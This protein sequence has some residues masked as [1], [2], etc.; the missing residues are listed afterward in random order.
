MARTI[1]ADAGLRRN[2]GPPVWRRDNPFFWKTLRAESRRSFLFV[3]MALTIATLAA[4]LLGGMA[5]ERR[6]DFGT[7]GLI[8]FLGISTLGLTFLAVSL[9]HT[10][11][12]LGARGALATSLQ[13]ETRRQTLEGLLLTPMPRAAMLLAMAVA[14][15]L[16]ASL[17]ALA[18]LPLYV[19]LN[20]LGG[21]EWR[22][23]GLLY[24]LFGLAAFAPPS[25][26]V[27]ALSGAAA[28]P[29]APQLMAVGRAQEQRRAEGAAGWSWFSLIWM[30]VALRPLLGVLGGSWLSH[31][32]SVLPPSVTRLGPLVVFAWPYSLTQTLGS[33][34]P[35]YNVHVVPFVYALPLIFG[36]WISS[37]L[38]SAAALTA[39]SPQEMIRTGLFRRHAALARL[40]NRTALLC[41]LGVMWRVWVLGGDTAA[42]TGHASLDPA[43]DAAGLLL[44]TGSVAQIQAAWRALGVAPRGKGSGRGRPPLRLVRRALRVAWRPL[45]LLVWMFALTCAFGGLSPFVGPVLGMAGRLGLVALACVVFAVGFHVWAASFGGKSGDRILGMVALLLALPFAA[46]SVPDPRF[47]GVAALSPATAWLGQFAG[48]QALLASW[49]YWKLGALPSAWGLTIAAPAVTGLLLGANGYARMKRRFVPLASAPAAPADAAAP[50]RHAARTASLLAWVTARTDN[51]LFT[52]ELRV[53]TRSGHWFSALYGVP[54]ALVLLVSVA[55][56]YPDYAHF[57]SFT[58]LFHPFRQGGFASGPPPSVFAD[59]AAIL[60]SWQIY[61][62][63]LNGQT[64]GESLIVRDQQRGT[65]GF[66]LLTPLRAGQIFWGKVWGQ[67]SGFGLGLILLGAGGLVLTLL[68]A[69]AIGLGPALSTW[70]GTQIFAL[71]LFT[72]SVS[73]GAALA[74]HALLLKSL[75][76]VSTL[77]VM[78]AL[79]GGVWLVLRLTPDGPSSW[80]RLGAQ[81]AVG[82]LCAFALS[83]PAFAYALWRFRA[84][85]RR[86]I[87]FGDQAG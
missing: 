22:D 68:A 27:P 73:L 50:A 23:V 58:A 33:P 48:A 52:H 29:D 36:G 25:Y 72:L 8:G 35:F 83:F 11:F 49:P 81:M 9:A 20:Q 44:L 86:D 70:A 14:P 32:L 84:L 12:V 43:W 56:R 82:S 34:L 61:L 77:L 6:L 1:A 66:L 28:T 31:G 4:L 37:T 59:L 51:P 42:L 63:A 38:K 55:V 21:A 7:R 74:T 17:V 64:I 87:T 67:T 10:L 80:Q 53:R 26:A 57:V 19:L 13:A 75:R 65:L 2:D 3:R 39:G 60:Q 46:L 15:A 45:R 79:A 16:G 40:L 18:G 47:W 54:L 69:P 71:S 30:F 62:C 78:A 76:G 85:R 24:V 41:F 5:L